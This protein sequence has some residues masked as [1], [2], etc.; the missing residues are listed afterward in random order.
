[1]QE[2]F[3]FDTRLGVTVLRED[4]DWT[5]YSPE[6]RGKIWAKWALLCSS[7]VG[8]VA[9]LEIEIMKKL[10]AMYEVKT[11]DEMHEINNEMMELASIVCDLNI[12]SRSVYADMAKA[13]F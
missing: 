6:E 9:E 13:H 8:R 11:E 4:I 12:L 1:M 7:M 2:A 5:R 10:D 3:T